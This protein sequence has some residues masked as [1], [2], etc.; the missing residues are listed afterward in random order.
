MTREGRLTAC[1]LEMVMRGGA[2]AATA[3]STILYPA[4]RLNGLYDLPA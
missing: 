4:A 2:Y 3:S 1:E